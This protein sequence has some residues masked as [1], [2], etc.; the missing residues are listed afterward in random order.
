M[1][2][3]DNPKRNALRMAV[4][5]TVLALTPRWGLTQAPDAEDAIIDTIRELQTINAGDQTRIANWVQTQVDRLAAGAAGDQ[6]PTVTWLFDRFRT[7][8]GNRKN[9]PA[10]RTQFA[11]Q[12][13]QVAASEFGK[14][15]LSRD[16][17]W[18]LAR[19]LVEL[20]APETV[21]AA[22]AGLKCSVP[23]ARYLCGKILLDQRDAIIRDKKVAEV[24]DA[25]KAAGLAEKD[26]TV[27]DTIYRALAY[28]GQ[29]GDVF[30]AYLAIFDVRLNFRR[31]P[32]VMADGAESGA[33]EFFRNPQVI[34]AVSAE[35]RAQLAQRI[36]VF[37][38]LDAERYNVPMLGE[39]ERIRL[40]FMLEAGEA[41]LAALTG[42]PAAINEELQKGGYASRAEILAQAYRWVG[43]GRANEAGTL[44][45]APWNVPIGAP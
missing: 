24:A 20:E 29:V 26:T 21:P 43:N 8:Y 2:N 42:K 39:E 5:S 13:A 6:N 18:G 27:L 19:V 9:S 3:G 28:Q 30:G 36:A 7:Q 38:R 31:G 22:L 40:E 41:V 33:F 37:L 32:N 34:A 1:Q 12:T 14:R 45:A 15:D 11:I 17:A 44:N 35:Q 25:L 10:F 16:V 23:A 4:L